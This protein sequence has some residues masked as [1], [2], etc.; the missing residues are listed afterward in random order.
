MKI[1]KVLIIVPLLVLLVALVTGSLLLWRLFILMLLV[2]LLGYLWTRLSMR[3]FAGEVKKTAASCYAGDYLEEVVSISNRSRLPTP[4]LK[5]REE[6]D[7]PGHHRI[8]STGLLPGGSHR[9]QTRIYC[10]HRGRYHLGLFTA[11]T[12]DPFGLFSAHLSFGERQEILVYPETVELPFLQPPSGIEAKYIY[13]PWSVTSAAPD[14]SR[15]REYVAGD[16]LNRI[17]WHSTA[18]AGKL[19]VKVLDP[20][21]PRRIPRNRNVWLILNLQQAAQ[22]G[23]ANETTEE[24]GIIAAAS[25]LKKYLE[26][27]KP[28]GL[29]ADGDRPYLFPPDTG[30]AYFWRLMESLALMQATG[31]LP[32]DR[33]VS[34]EIGRLEA[35]S[36]VMV[37]TP[38]TAEGIVPSLRALA[39]HGITV[40]AMLLDAS[41]FGG[42]AKAPK[43]A[44][45]L[46][47]TGAQIYVIRRGLEIKRRADSR[48]L[49]A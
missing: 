12:G 31:T 3:R 42:S 49:T 4:L 18:H 40:T 22:S 29:M 6:T 1:R 14:V 41:S 25:L 26:N 8:M 39:N 10:Q 19:M 44:L 15:V 38:S 9:W 23:T 47:S 17:Q 20:D 11:S 5:I 45:S 43:T 16:N 27:G 7:L 32:L 48:V 2:L 35:S 33:L 30:D 28:V 46:A 24:Y 36:A 13:N 37:I 34:Q 21:R